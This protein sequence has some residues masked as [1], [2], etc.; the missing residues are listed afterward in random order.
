MSLPKN[1]N[2]RW[3]FI[4]VALI[5]GIFATVGAWGLQGMVMYASLILV[6][7][8]TA[9]PGPPSP[10]SR[11]LVLFMGV[12]GAMVG[13]CLLTGWFGYVSVGQGW[14]RG[15]LSEIGGWAAGILVAAW[16]ASV[17]FE[18]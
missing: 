11:V 12:G 5:A 3:M 6:I 9:A 13:W 7:V 8:I 2:L 15:S 18:K 10:V 14:Y 17:V 4:A 1:F 16:R